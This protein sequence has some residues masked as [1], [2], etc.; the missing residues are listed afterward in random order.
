[1]KKIVSIAILTLVVASMICGIAA[2][3]EDPISAGPAPNSS[4]GIPG[5]DQ[6]AK[7][8]NPG[9]GPAPNSGDG[10]SDGSGF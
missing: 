4:D 1:M 5:I 9:T 3:V 8:E 2:A 6:N 7:P 10:I